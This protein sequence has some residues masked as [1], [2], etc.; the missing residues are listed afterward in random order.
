MAL[1]TLV[2]SA[3]AL[4][5]I[6]YFISAST[7]QRQHNL[8]PGPKPLPILGNMLDFP[9][10]G[11]AEHK[12]WLAHKDLYGGLSSVSVLGTT[13]VI[14]H[15]REIAHSLLDQLSA[16]TSGRPSMVMAGK[17]C[18]YEKIVLCQGYDASFRRNRRFLHRELGT[19]VSA[20]QFQAVQE[21]EVNRLLVRALNEPEAWLEHLKTAAGATVLKMA[22]GYTI[23]PHKPD[24]LVTLI[25]KMMTEFSL[26]SVPMGWAVDI[27]PALQ[28]L[29]ENFPGAGFQKTARKWR[30]SIQDSAHI[31]Y[32]FAWQQL[33]SSQAKPSFVSKLI[34][35]LKAEND[36]ILD[37]EDEQAIIWTAASLYGAAADT[38]VI[39]L[40]AF[41]A[42]MIMYPDVQRKAQEEIDRVVGSD[43]LPTFADRER[44]PYINALVKEV[45]RWWPVAPMGF[46]HTATED[47]EY[48]GYR[49]PKGSMLL[50][51]VWWFTHDPAVHADPDAFDPDRFLAP[52]NEPESYMELWGYGRRICPGRFFA[53][54][55][56]YLNIVQSLAVFDLRKAVG[57]D[58]VEIGLDMKPKPGVLAYPTKFEYRIEPRS[59]RHVE[60]IRK[61]E[62][63]VGWEESDAHKLD[64]V[65]KFEVV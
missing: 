11:T 52:R 53:D 58:G 16:K 8:P 59:E 1:T 18:G 12:H 14:I 29:P 51:A 23:D 43:T 26:A 31:P 47:I 38:T 45:L 10:A 48:G 13:M 62:D 37:P 56:L 61:A 25:D 42:A 46:P 65:D 9:P 2:L 32:W 39:A 54:A 17:L 28:H 7:Q 44:L 60:L 24:P 41:T 40:T 33:E 55:G 6:A 22:Y 57:E 15:D 5:F 50:P 36:G 63:T 3:L 34:Q 4:T 27:I 30:K 20:A 64:S 35:Q 49:I 21:V 19:K